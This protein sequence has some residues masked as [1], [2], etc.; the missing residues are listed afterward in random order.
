MPRPKNT[1]RDNTIRQRRQA[2]E[3]V[4]S[5]AEAFGVTPQRID[6]ICV[7]IRHVDKI[8]YYTEPISLATEIEKAKKESSSAPPYKKGRLVWE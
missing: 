1:A 6:H 3:T 2:G 7:G 8:R 5:L 4:T